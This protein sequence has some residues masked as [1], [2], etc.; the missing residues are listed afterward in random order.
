MQ[1]LERHKANTRQN[2]RELSSGFIY[3]FCS[4]QRQTIELSTQNGT[5]EYITGSIGSTLK[6]LGQPL[7][8]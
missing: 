3:V 8:T 4:Y 1:A 6:F 2:F 7:S 5:I